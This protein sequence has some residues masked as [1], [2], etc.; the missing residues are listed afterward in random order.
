MQGFQQ[1]K[2]AD[3]LGEYTDKWFECILG[4]FKNCERRFAE[5]V[6]YN[7]NP[8]NYVK[9]PEILERL[10]TLRSKVTEE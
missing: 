5:A 9:T 2:Q 7:L 4:V 6:Y 10:K 8:A 1:W 3:I